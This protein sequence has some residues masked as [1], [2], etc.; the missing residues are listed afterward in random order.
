[1]P[2]RAIHAD[3]VS[4]GLRRQLGSGTRVTELYRHIAI[5]IIFNHPDKTIFYR[6]ALLSVPGAGTVASYQTV[7]TLFMTLP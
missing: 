1:M 6:S 4:A 3:I 2:F 7:F 5:T